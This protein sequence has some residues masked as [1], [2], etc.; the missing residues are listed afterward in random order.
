MNAPT[1]PLPAVIVVLALLPASVLAAPQVI[2]CKG[3]CYVL[4]EQGI[5]RPA[6][7]GTQLA[8]RGRFETGPD[9]Y[10]QIKIGPD[11]QIG[12]GEHAR[13]RFDEATFEDRSVVLLYQGRVRVIVGAPARRIELRTRDGIFALRGADVEAK[14]LGAVGTAPGLTYVKLNAG[15]AQL[16]GSQGDFAIGK[17]GVQGVTRGSMIADRSFSLAEVAVAPP[18][19]A[20]AP[21]EV[22]PV[23]DIPSTPPA[24]R[25]AQIPGIATSFAPSG[26]ESKDALA[27]QT[28]VGRNSP[29]GLQSV[30]TPKSRPIPPAVVVGKSQRGS[31]P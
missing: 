9:T 15:D 6:P 16:R 3:E 4:D 12:I 10:A 13:V 2:F 26:V 14:T 22:A 31:K 23:T 20:S 19:S 28:G 11:A 21:T 24:V 29:H 25:N 18:K 30:D 5:R 1:R 8:E 7:K 27:L 17:Q